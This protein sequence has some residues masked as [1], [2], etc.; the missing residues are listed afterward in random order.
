MQAK[1]SLDEGE[2][3]LHE[4]R[5]ADDGGEFRSR[6]KLKSLLFDVA[7]KSAPPVVRGTL[8]NEGGD[9]L[10]ELVW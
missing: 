2:P 1:V 8:L 10:H 3:V 4:S 9:P 5:P 7:S 6:I